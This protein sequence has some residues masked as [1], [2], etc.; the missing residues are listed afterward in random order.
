M[1][2]LAGVIDVKLGDGLRA[3]ATA[4]VER[5]HHR[6]P[7]AGGVWSDPALGVALAHRRLAVVDLS[8][9]GAQPMTLGDLTVVFNGEIYNWRALRSELEALGQRFRS[10]SDTE[11]LL[12]A[13]RQWGVVDTLPR[14]RGMFAFA[15][16]DGAQRELWLARDRMGEKPLCWGQLG[17]A[18]VFASETLALRAHPQWRGDIDR[19]ALA[20]YVSLGWIPA[21]R[22]IYR[23]IAK[24][25]PGTW[26]RIRIGDGAP[27]IEGPTAWWSTAAVA[28]QGRATPFTGDLA[29]A[30]KQLESLL[31]S[32]VSEQMLADVPLGAFLSGGIDSSVVVALMQAQATQPIRTFTSGFREPGFDEAGHAHRV[33]THLGTAHTE[34]YVD[35]A[36]ARA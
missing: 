33:A 28:A 32:A 18:I 36:E 15:L 2:G 21:P 11:V 30:S 7:D 20:A 1:C 3:T 13:C 19:D 31:R 6:G 34:L 24:L 27:R 25:P 16:W 26:L 12:A 4:M 8:V 9:D 23:G 10:N 5:L 35:E 29:D 22:T 17:D 14:L